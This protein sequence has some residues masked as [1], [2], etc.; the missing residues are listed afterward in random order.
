MSLDVDVLVELEEE[1]Y[2]D[3]VDRNMAAVRL[4]VIELDD[5]RAV[6]EDQNEIETKPYRRCKTE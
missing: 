4:V 5:D 6:L 2:G 1:M 3:F